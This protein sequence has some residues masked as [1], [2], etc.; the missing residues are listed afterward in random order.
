MV[1]RE[2]HRRGAHSAGQTDAEPAYRKLQ[3]PASRRVSERELVLEPVR[4]TGEDRG[5]AGRLQLAAATLGAEVLNTG[6]VRAQG[7]FAFFSVEY[8]TSGSA[9]RLP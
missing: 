4:R 7:R 1:H 3:R 8:H 9:S 2:A 5:L 6:R